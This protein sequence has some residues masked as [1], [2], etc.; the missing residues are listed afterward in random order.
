MSLCAGGPLGI[1]QYKDLKGK[2]SAVPVFILRLYLCT[3][4]SEKMLLFQ[5]LHHF[6]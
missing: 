6:A 4:K 2:S 3:K 5:D 1:Q